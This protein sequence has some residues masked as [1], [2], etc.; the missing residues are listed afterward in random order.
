MKTPL[1]ILFDFAC[2]CDVGF[3]LVS[4]VS[5]VI[6]TTLE[7]IGLIFSFFK[8][9]NPAEYWP[10]MRQGSGGLIASLP[11][12]IEGTPKSQVHIRNMFRMVHGL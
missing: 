5:G 3:Y 8:L 4:L 6:D 12:W 10:L 11:S 9:E 7:A 1:F 2:M